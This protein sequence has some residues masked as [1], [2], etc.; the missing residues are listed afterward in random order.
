MTLLDF[1]L[2]ALAT[3]RLS[4]L[5]AYE[6]GPAAILET[7]RFYVG[8]TPVNCAEQQNSDRVTNVFCCIKCLSVWVA[9]VILLLW[10]YVPVVVWALAASAGAILVQKWMTQ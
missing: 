6:T 2:I 10:L 8:A 5:L 4:A 7:F 3:W 1:L 9:P